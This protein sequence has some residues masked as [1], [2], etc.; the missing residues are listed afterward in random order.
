MASWSAQFSAC[1]SLTH[2]PHGWH[3]DSRIKC[4]SLALTGRGCLIWPLSNRS[5][6]SCHSPC[7]FLVPSGT[8]GLFPAFFTCSFP[9]RISTAQAPPCHLHLSCDI[10]SSKKPSLTTW[11]KT[12][13]QSLSFKFPCFNSSYNST[14]LLIGLSS[15]IH[16]LHE[17]RESYLTCGTVE[18]LVSVKRDWHVIVVQLITVEWRIG[19]I[20]SYVC[21]CVYLTFLYISL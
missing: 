7:H 5:V 16:K 20:L 13:T 14:Y 8:P 18:L 17:R 15:A 1:P 19:H 9:R 10:T 12:A 6:N 3:G 21:V 11:S 2:P 4:R